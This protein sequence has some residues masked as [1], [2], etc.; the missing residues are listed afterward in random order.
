MFAAAVIVIAAPASAIP[1]TFDFSGRI[2]SVVII[3]VAAGAPTFDFS[4]AGQAFS[5]QFIIDTDLFAPAA[6]PLSDLGDRLAFSSELPGAVNSSLV[7]NGESIDFAPFSRNRA[8]VSFLDSNGVVSCGVNCQRLAPD[9]FSLNLLSEDSTPVGLSA[10]RAL[11]FGFVA[12]FAG[13]DN[14]EAATSW[15]DFSPDFGITQLATL[16]LL[17]SLMPNVSLTDFLF[18]C[19][20]VQCQQ[21]GSRRTQFEVTSATRTVASVPEPGSLGLLAAGLAV[22]WFTRRRQA[23][24]A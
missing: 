5:A 11:S 12:G 22:A 23:Q 3:D 18:A 7:V 24:R 8:N 14:P 20:E 6:P 9:Q 2:A 16:P 10:A 4:T 13:F 19:T 15:F 1:V 21:T 17:D